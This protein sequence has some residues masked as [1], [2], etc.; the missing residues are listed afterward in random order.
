MSR[1]P[2]AGRVL[3]LGAGSVSQCTVPLLVDH[4]VDRPDRI[5]ILDF[6]DNRDR[7]ADVLAKGVTYVTDRVTRENLPTLLGS[8]LG[9][10]DLLVDLAWNIDANAILSWCHDR[11]VL[12]LN[13]SVEVWDPYGDA[14]S[15]TPQE[16]TLY[17]RH[18]AMRELRDSY[19]RPGATAVV[20][21]GANPGLVSHWTKQALVDIATAAVRDGLA[22]A[23]VPAALEAERYG[24]LAEALGVKVIHIAERDTQISD[25]PKLV[26]EFVNTWSIAGFHEEGIAP[27][28]MGW[29]THER[30]LP[31]DAY[32]HA[33]GPRNQICLARPGAMTWVRS[34]VPHHEINGMVIRHGEAFTIADHLTTWNADGSARYRP[35][36]HY[37]YCPTDLAIASM[38]E[39]SARNWELPPKLRIMNEEI[40]DGEDR[41][42]VLLMGHPYT[43]WWT[44]SLLSIHEARRHAPGQSAT[45]LQVAASILGALTWIVANPERG[46]LV[47]DDLPWR[48]VLAVA[49]PF[50]GEH[51]SGAADWTPVRDRYDVFEGWRSHRYDDDPWQF[52]NFL[53]D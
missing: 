17:V 10:G 29:G 42:G 26:D 25:R 28:E 49:E 41:L 13:T 45:T 47:P 36:V 3:V 12:Y 20:E 22:K 33:E 23:A 35:T 18:M 9:A 50:L 11:G 52:A 8:Y 51:W 16:R 21:H 32:E 7:F 19:E 31:A 39:L 48:E 53:V 30:T 4:L 24:D 15:M 34:W 5:T 2:Y 40:T 1:T 14:R 46:I 38:R 6:T 44:G 27:A 37:A 43:A